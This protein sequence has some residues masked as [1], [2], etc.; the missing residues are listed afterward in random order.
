MSEKPPSPEG[1]TYKF[2]PVEG[3]AD[4]EELRWRLG[5]YF[6]NLEMA[7]NGASAY[8][9]YEKEID[10]LES[11][12]IEVVGENLFKQLLHRLSFREEP[13]L[14]YSHDEFIENFVDDLERTVQRGGYDSV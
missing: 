2:M 1:F 6:S 7:A 10:F 9:N 13:F 12:G 8:T 4:Q 5:M 14:V 11:E 3:V